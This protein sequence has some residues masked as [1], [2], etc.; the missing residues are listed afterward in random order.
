MILFTLSSVSGA[1]VFA[2]VV[3]LNRRSHHQV[4]ATVSVFFVVVLVCFVQRVVIARKRWSEAGACFYVDASRATWKEGICSFYVFTW[5]RYLVCFHWTCA[6]VSAAW[7]SPLW[8]RSSSHICS[9]WN[10]GSAPGQLPLSNLFLSSGTWCPWRDCEG[11]GSPAKTLCVPPKM[12]L[13][14]LGRRQLRRLRWRML[15]SPRRWCFRRALS[16]GRRHGC[17]AH[18]YL[19]ETAAYT[20]RDPSFPHTDPHQHHHQHRRWGGDYRHHCEGKGVTTALC[21]M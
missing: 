12:S 21:T 15:P 7:F 17:L 14:P 8:R 18:A 3:L 1:Y 11:G 20:Q 13:S 9:R 10:L 4:S 16:S 2:T 19:R 5:G 6:P